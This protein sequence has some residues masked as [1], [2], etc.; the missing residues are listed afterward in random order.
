MSNNTENITRTLN[1]GIESGNAKIHMN[2]GH[3]ELNGNGI[4]FTGSF[5]NANNDLVPVK[6]EGYE[7]VVD[8]KDSSPWNGMLSSIAAEVVKNVAI[9]SVSKLL[10]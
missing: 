6:N 2:S 5:A 10:Q 3:V 4:N 7:E 1:I 8:D 9:S